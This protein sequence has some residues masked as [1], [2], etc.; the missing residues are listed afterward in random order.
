MKPV[1]GE[2]W[3]VERSAHAACC[4]NYGQDHPQ[5]L[6]YG[7]RG[8]SRDTLEDMWMLDVDIGKWT[9]VSLEDDTM[10]PVFTAESL[11]HISKWS[12]V[13]LIWILCTHMWSVLL[14]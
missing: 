8:K 3:P 1:Q 14:L 11:Q 7:G 12:Y 9:A 10:Q 5:L 6:V 13:F 4:L 2:P